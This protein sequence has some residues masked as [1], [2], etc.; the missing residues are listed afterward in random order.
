MAHPLATSHPDSLEVRDERYLPNVFRQSILPFKG[1]A[2]GRVALLWFNKLVG[3]RADL[4]YS[5]LMFFLDWGEIG[6]FH[7]RCPGYWV[8]CVF[9]ILGLLVRLTTNSLELIV[10]LVPSLIG[11]GISISFIGFVLGPIYPIVMNH[12][13][14]ILPSWILTGSIGWIAGFGVAGSACIPFI[15]GVIASHKGIESLQP[16]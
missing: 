6:G 16:L 2:L 4:A 9:L 13:A 11:D 5:N 7:L 14:R 10:W 15:T 8:C 12:S 3:F 1:L